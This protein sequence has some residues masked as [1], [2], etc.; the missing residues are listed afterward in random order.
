MSATVS[1]SVARKHLTDSS[2]L[3]DQ[4]RF[5][6]AAY[7]S[8]YVVECCLKALLDIDGMPSGKELGHELPLMAGNALMLG[9]ALAPSRRRY[10]LA[11]TP[12]LDLLI[13]DWK[14]DAR[15]EKE[16]TTTLALAESR[17]RGARAAYEQIV[18]A[19]IL[20]GTN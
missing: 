20:D 5:D 11:A 19:M 18:V 16:N 9:Y 15:Y 8:G 12:D 17:V 4:K 3:L 13:K 6:N 14:P 10:N 1:I 7:L 2:L